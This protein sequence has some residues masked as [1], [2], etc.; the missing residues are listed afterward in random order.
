MTSWIQQPIVFALFCG[1]LYTHLVWS[2]YRLLYPA[3]NL[4][5]TT[6]LRTDNW[7]MWFTGCKCIICWPHISYAGHTLCD[8][9]TINMSCNDQSFWD[10]LTISVLC[11]QHSLYYILTI[12]VPCTHHSLCNLQTIG[13]S[14]TD[15]SLW[16]IL[17]ISVSCTHHSVCDLLTLVRHALTTRGIFWPIVYRALITEYAKSFSV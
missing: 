11:T 13:T 3:Y 2:R 12:S 1:V 6:V 9:L 14:C 8:I 4:L 10:I 17:T 7:I 15:H 5:T 16:D